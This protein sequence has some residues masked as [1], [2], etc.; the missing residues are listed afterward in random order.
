MRT[1]VLDLQ[2]TNVYRPV[3][4]ERAVDLKE[5]A[6]NAIDFVTNQRS[7]NITQANT[8]LMRVRVQANKTLDTAV[9]QAAVIAKNA[10]AEGAIVYGKYASQAALYK[11]VRTDRGLSSEGLLAYIGTRLID[12]LDHITVGL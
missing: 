6:R 9:T 12:E 3:L 7:M 10:E 11:K 5:N 1:F 8:N 2:L 4:Y